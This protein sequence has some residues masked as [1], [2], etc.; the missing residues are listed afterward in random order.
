[1]KTQSIQNE[2][3][4]MESNLGLLKDFTSYSPETIFSIVGQIKDSITRLELG[5]KITFS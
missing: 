2:L 5:L 1:M 4:I 3:Y